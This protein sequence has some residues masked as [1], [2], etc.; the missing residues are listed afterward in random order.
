[1]APTLCH[2]SQTS[3]EHASLTCVGHHHP[4]APKRAPS[5][6]ASRSLKFV[7]SP[8]G[9]PSMTPAIAKVSLNPVP[10]T[11]ATSL[12]PLHS[13]FDITL[14]LLIRVQFSIFHH[15]P[16]VLP[17]LLD[18]LRNPFF[19]SPALMPRFRRCLHQSLLF[20]L[21]YYPS[22]AFLRSALHVL[23]TLPVGQVI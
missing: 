22:R 19:L 21:S 23:A 6:T 3:R 18:Q 16:I 15:R 17:I 5:R 13:P 12:P 11:P 4:I 14:S 1:M 20:Q 7:C 9:W 10:S 2:H 8:F